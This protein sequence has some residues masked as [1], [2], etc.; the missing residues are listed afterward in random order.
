MARTT[1]FTNCQIVDLGLHWKFLKSCKIWFL[2]VD[3]AENPLVQKHLNVLGC[4]LEVWEENVAMSCVQ[5]WALQT[6]ES[7]RRQGLQDSRV[8]ANVCKWVGGG[9]VALL[10]TGCL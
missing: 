8:L 1:L 10:I 6:R 9:A 5:Y 3:V 2:G 7:R 4:L